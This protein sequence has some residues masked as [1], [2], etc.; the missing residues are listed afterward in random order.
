M[1]NLSIEKVHLDVYFSLEYKGDMSLLTTKEV[2]ERLG[3]SLRRVQAMITAGRL[4]AQKMG[5]DYF[6]QESDLKLVE[7]RK[8]GRPPKAEKD[9][10]T[11]TRT[12]KK[13]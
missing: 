10:D 2:A 11:V 9:K 12:R 5:R 13:A 8:S 6:V 1:Y 4:S 7:G 3:V